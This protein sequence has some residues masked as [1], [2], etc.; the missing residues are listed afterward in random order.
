[1]SVHSITPVSCFNHCSKLVFYK[2]FL[3]TCPVCGEPLSDFC[4]PPFQLPFPFVNATQT[5]T[6]IVIRPSRGTFL[7]DYE[8][9]DDLHIA[10]VDSRSNIYEFDRHGIVRNDHQMWTSC[11]AI[12][13][14]PESWFNHWD[15]TLL[16]TV[17]DPIWTSENYQQQSFNCFNFVI[18]FLNNL[19]YP[20][21]EFTSKLGICQK[22]IMPKIHEVMR[23]VH[24]H[25]KLSE[26]DVYVQN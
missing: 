3:T 1:M 11:A 8:I 9:S 17:S 6:S 12:N 20:D 5:P 19:K 2:T 18:A 26:M 22:V 25:R 24:I 13:F 15:Q 10:I 14:V 7:T 16:D 4:T 21:F 23:Y